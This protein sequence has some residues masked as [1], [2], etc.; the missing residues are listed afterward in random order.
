[1]PNSHTS[2]QTILSSFMCKYSV[3]CKTYIRFLSFCAAM[4]FTTQI[5]MQKVNYYLFMVWK[6]EKLI[7]YRSQF[8]YRMPLLAL[9]NR[10]MHVIRSYRN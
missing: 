1:M 9:Y 7:Q 8:G 3:Q 10:L 6:G 4:K 5:V 2:S